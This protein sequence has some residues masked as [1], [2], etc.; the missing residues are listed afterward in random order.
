MQ[1]HETEGAARG[2]AAKIEM[3]HHKNARFIG[4][5]QQKRAWEAC[6][7][8]KHLVVGLGLH[9]PEEQIAIQHLGGRHR[10]SAR[11]GAHQR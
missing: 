7:G 11:S 4:V 9:L 10:G 1:R 3:Q 2:R 6:D 5:E 8:E